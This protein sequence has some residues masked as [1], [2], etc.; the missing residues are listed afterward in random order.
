[1]ILKKSKSFI[2][3]IFILILILGAFLRFYRM[4]EYMTF[5]GDEGRDMLVVKR[6]IVDHK[7]TLLGPITSVGSMYM[8]P[9]YYYF[10]VPFLWLW[11]FDPLGPS[12]M[13]AIFSLLTIILLYKLCS[14]YFSPWLGII[15]SFIYS[16]S[17][18]TVIY[19]KSS[20]NPN[21]VPFFSLAII[22]T[23]MKVTGD[24]KYKWFFIT[25]LCLGILIQLHYVP[26]LFIPII[27]LVLSLIRFKI[28][29][30]YYIFC[31]LGF[32][33]TYSPFLLFELRH[34]FVNLHSVWRFIW[35]QKRSQTPTIFSGIKTSYDVFIRLFWRL[36]IIGNAE[37]SKLLIAGLILSLIFW[38]KTKADKKKRLFIKVILIWI[39]AGS[40]S[41][42]I[43]QGIIYDYYF[44]SLFPAP[45][46]LSSFFILNMF[47]RNNLG[48]I[49][50]VF[51]LGII[52]WF[53]YQNSPFRIEPNNMMKNTETISRFVL[54]KTSGKPYNFALIAD[55]NSD[56]AYRY[57][58]EIWGH[59]PKTIENSEVDP[60]RKTVTGQLL[61]VCEE[62]VCQPLGH[63]KWEIAG[64]GR[65]EIAGEWK[66]VTTK[67][68][69]ME[70]YKGVQNE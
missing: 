32:I 25:G 69:R 29:Y 33:I 46:I 56:Q 58:L 40:L 5:L 15:A 21:I 18:L 31:F 45:I 20:W 41:F 30:K 53:N 27:I 35:E 7:Y 62:K 16:I 60:E 1:M 50:S 6:M 57:F 54:D 64:F 14:E 9:V 22:Y 47:T 13:V 66:V 43:Y 8:G 55:H 68:F 38:F 63:P 3:F 10:M 36:V 59:P 42:G 49:I 70:H 4:R 26:L 24:K 61:I 52:I 34:N 67:V 12:V 48:K 39:I 23:L 19:G 17:R 11:H 2:T 28:P 37:L 51:T 44:G 65:A